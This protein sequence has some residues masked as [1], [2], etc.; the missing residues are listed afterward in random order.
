MNKFHHYL[1]CFTLLFV[2]CGNLFAQES[3]PKM[4]EQSKLNLLKEQ[5]TISTD[6]SIYAVGED[7]FFDIQC[8]GN[9]FQRKTISGIVYLELLASSGLPVCQ[10]KLPL[11]SNA[12]EGHLHIPQGL[13]SGYYYLRAYTKWMCN[14]TSNE[15]ELFEI[16]IINPVDGSILL[17]QN[18]AMTPPNPGHRDASVKVITSE[19]T[20]KTNSFVDV[21]LQLSTQ[22]PSQKYNV[23]VVRKGAKQPTQ[24]FIHKSA[25][26]ESGEGVVHL[27]EAYGLVLTGRVFESDTQHS[28]DGA[29]VMLTLVDEIPYLCF[30]HTDDNGCFSFT[31]PNLYNIKDFYINALKDDLLLDVRVDNDFCWRDIDRLNRPFML[32]ADEQNLVQEICLN[33][34]INQRFMEAINNGSVSESPEFIEFFGDPDVVYVVDDYVDLKTVQDFIQEVVIEAIVKDWTVLLSNNSQGFNTLRSLPY[35]VLLDHIPITDQEALLQANPRKIDRIELVKS[36]YLVGDKSYCG[37]ISIT[38]KGNDMAGIELPQNGMF[39]Q[40]DMFTKMSGTFSDKI[41][42]S[43]NNAK[44]PDRRNC[45]YWNSSMTVG[46]DTKIRFKTSDEVGEYQIIVQSVDLQTGA[47]VYQEKSFQV[48][49]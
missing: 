31:L 41:Q 23:S 38:S 15:E 9:L 11:V 6:R 32:S 22:D 33:A 43:V 48:T 28:V 29:Q 7:L 24:P 27:P 37:V 14:Q 2:A 34:Q 47:V 36:A 5:V 1:L 40:Y 4:K 16:K 18:E 19:D 30:C 3:A 45:L 26:V 21:D 25:E 12:A 10:L 44:V 13:T 39:F 49:N 17:A 35:L 46:D 42:A 8:F 20:Y